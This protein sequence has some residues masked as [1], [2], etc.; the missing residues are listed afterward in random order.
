MVV[1]RLGIGGSR[2]RKDRRPV[3][4]GR[5]NRLENFRDGLEDYAYFRILEATVKQVESSPGLR[6]DRA[7]WLKEAKARL[8]VPTKLVES[9]TEYSLDPAAVLSWRK[10]LAESIVSAGILAPTA[11][12]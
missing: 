2:A 9:L 6:A 11:R 3:S 8:Q 10:T 4:R 5:K 12:Q 1:R 7:G